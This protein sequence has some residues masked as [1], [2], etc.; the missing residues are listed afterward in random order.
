MTFV[1][2]RFTQQYQVRANAPMPHQY[3]YGSTD[4]RTHQHIPAN[5]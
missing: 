3:L 5:A 1:K 2:K 4:S